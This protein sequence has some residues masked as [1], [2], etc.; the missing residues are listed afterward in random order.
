M[1]RQTLFY[2]SLV[3]YSAVFLVDSLLVAIGGEIALSVV[4]TAIASVFV[5]GAS[6]YALLNP[7]RGGGMADSWLAYLVAVGAAVVITIVVTGWL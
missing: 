6:V 3:V 7:E 2:S 1:D 4:G 5:L